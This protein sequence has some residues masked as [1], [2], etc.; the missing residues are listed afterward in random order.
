MSATET[1]RISGGDI[2]T[3]T[4]EHSGLSTV[5]FHVYDDLGGRT[6]QTHSVIVS[7]PK[8]LPPVISAPGEAH[9]GQTVD[10]TID[11]SYQ[12][13]DATYQY[14]IDW[15]G[16]GQ[17]DEQII[18]GLTTKSYHTNMTNLVNT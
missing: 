2:I 16:D 3:H 11:G 17:S 12:T 10:L 5:R 14:S 1:A 18:G 9:V 4:F 6:T 8:I 15:D 7:A 13:S